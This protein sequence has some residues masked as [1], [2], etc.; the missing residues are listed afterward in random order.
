MRRLAARDRGKRLLAGTA[1]GIGGCQR[2]KARTFATRVRRADRDFRHH[3]EASEDFLILPSSFILSQ[4]GRP[5]RC[6]RVR[7]GAH[8][9]LPGGE[10]AH[11]EVTRR[12]AEGRKGSARSDEGLR[13][14]GCAH[15][16]RA[17]EDNGGAGA[18]EAIAPVR[19]FNRR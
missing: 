4:R 12:N 17:P 3:P 18:W 2:E 15:V 1:R 16:F 8:G 14:S 5:H 9:Q 13:A 7:G 6:A 11:G 19:N 10:G